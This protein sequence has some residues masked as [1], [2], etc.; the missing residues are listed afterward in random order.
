MSLRRLFPLL[1][2]ACLLVPVSTLAASAGKSPIV[3]RLSGLQNNRHVYYVALLEQSL[4]AAGYPVQI[5]L[6]PPIPPLRLWS[7]VK[8]GNIT[9]VWGVQTAE[10]DQDLIGVNNRLTNGLIGL[11][12]LMVP[13]GSEDAYANVRS[14]KDL[15]ALKKVGGAGE[16]WFDVELWRLN[17]LPLVVRNGD[18]NHLFRMVAAGDRR[19]DYIIRGAHEAVADLQANPDL[20]IEPHL[21]LAHERDMRFYLGRGNSALAP[22]LEQ[23]LA[24]ADRSGLKKRLIAEYLQPAMTELKIER[25]QRLQLTT[26]GL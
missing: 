5:E 18:W 1:L 12:V 24:R 7:D 6:L 23:A 13:K 9:L 8:A 20:V 16:G 14:L 19:V 21:L 4:K 25:R 22:I 17:N 26:P 3:L 15:R 10:R 11:R 2:I